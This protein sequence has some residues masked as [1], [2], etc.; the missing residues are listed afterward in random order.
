MK[1]DP[2]TSRLNKLK[3]ETMRLRNQLLISGSNM[4]VLQNLL[5]L[6]QQLRDLDTVEGF[7]G[8]TKSWRKNCSGVLDHAARWMRTE[9]AALESRDPKLARKL[10]SLAGWTDIALAYVFRGQDD[11][12]PPVLLTA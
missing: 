11:P 3:T 5:E 6:E 8:R 12:S 1:H 7:A 10:R 2:I 4:L 9:A